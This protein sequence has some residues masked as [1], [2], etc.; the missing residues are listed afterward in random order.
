M[1][2]MGGKVY[3]NWRI[4]AAPTKDVRFAICGTAAAMIQA[5]AQYIGTGGFLVS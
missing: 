1:S 3:E 2:S 4:Q 5:S